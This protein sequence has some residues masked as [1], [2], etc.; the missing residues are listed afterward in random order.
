MPTSSVGI[1]GL[2]PAHAGKT[3]HGRSCAPTRWAHPR[4]RGENRA[5]AGLGAW[6]QGSS[7][8]TRGKR[9]FPLVSHDVLRLIPAHAGKTLSRPLILS[10]PWAHPRSRGEN[11]RSLASRACRAGSSPLTRGKRSRPCCRGLG[12]GLIPA[13]AGK[14]C[15]PCFGA[16]VNEAHPRSRGENGVVVVLDEAE[17]GS[18]PLTRGKLP[19][20]RAL[21]VVMGL[22]PAHAGKTDLVM[23]LP[24]TVSAHPRSRGENFAVVA[25]MICA[26]G[27]SPLTRGKHRE[28]KRQCLKSRLIPAHA[29]KTSIRFLSRSESA[30]HPRSRGENSWCWC[31]SWRGFGSS[32]L[33]RG[34][35]RGWYLPGCARGLIPAHAGKTPRLTVMILTTWAHP[36]SRGENQGEVP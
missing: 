9:R 26:M 34:K 7:P 2:I 18:S 29:G 31:R 23:T 4:S 30:A 24:V 10:P 27:S 8:L 14:T 35:L 22:I 3:G 19:Q 33:T 36:R 13:H 6:H 15:G 25:L 5:C 20:V 1:F 12:N 17:C 21:A 16:A 11:E 28:R 32:P